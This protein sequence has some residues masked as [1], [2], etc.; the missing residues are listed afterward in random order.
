ME[1]ANINGRKVLCVRV[2]NCMTTR[3]DAINFRDRDLAERK[4]I[5]LVASGVDCECVKM[6]RVIYLAVR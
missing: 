6:G 5:E 3:L 1:T 2:K 4:R